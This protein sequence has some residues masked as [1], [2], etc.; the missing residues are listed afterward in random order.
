MQIEELLPASL[1][2]GYKR[3]LVQLEQPGGRIAPDS[4]LESQARG[5]T[6]VNVDE[7]CD[8][9]PRM[10]V[11]KLVGFWTQVTRA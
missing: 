3:P 4:I 7:A 6:L 2:P 8:V 1:W 11:L 9:V 10:A 5:C